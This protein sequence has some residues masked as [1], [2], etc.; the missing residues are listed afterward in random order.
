M[1]FYQYSWLILFSPLFAFAVIIFGTRMWDL[2]TRRSIA[3]AAGDEAHAHSEGE[4][5]EGPE[6]IETRGPHGE[7]ETLEDDEDPKV[8][9]LTTGAR[10]S[11]YVGIVIMALAC[12]YSWLIL[13]NSA[14]VFSFAPPLPASGVQVL[15]FD[16][17][18]QGTANYIIAFRLDHLAAVMMVVVTTVSL[19]VQFYSQ[20]YMENSAGYARFFSYLSLFAFSMLDI[21]FAQNLLVIFIG[22]ELVGLSSYLL[23]GFWINKRAKPEEDRLSPASASIEAF[24]TTRIGDVGFI[25]GIMILFAQTGTFDFSTLESSTDPHGVAHAFAGNTTLLTVAM[26]LVF[27]GAIGKSAQLP[28]SVWLPPA[29]EG[30]TPVS[31]LIHAATMVAAGVYMVARTFPLFETAGPAAFQVV[32]WVGAITAIYAALTALTQRDFKRVLAFSTISQL[33]Y[34]FVGLGVAGA[35]L[36]PGPG[37]FHL[38]THA[39]FKALLF[40]GAGSVIH[41]LHHATHK[42]VQD[43]NKMGGLAKFMP[44]TAVTWLIATLA[45]SGF[46]FFSGFY[47]KDNIIGLAYQHGYY[48]LYA[49]TLITAGLTAFYMLR[50]YILA[51]GGRVGEEGARFGGLW[52]GTYRGEGTPHESPLTITIP[53][54]LLSI[55]AIF[56]GYWT[57][58]FG[59][60]QPGAP[61]LDLGEVFTDPLTWIGVVVSLIGLGWA[62]V[63]YTRFALATIRDV[64]EG[65]V[66]L[67]FLH[68]L[69]LR[70]FYLDDIY[71]WL[72]R[73]VV[74]GLSHIEAAFDTYVVD[75][76]V[77]GVARAV[78]GAG[79]EV[80][81]AET[82]RVQSYMIGFFGGLAVL[83]IVVFALV[84]FVK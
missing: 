11:G 18:V 63:L 29:M 7:E 39:F 76:I 2:A 22:W 59:Y 1:A 77:N 43:M 42:E 14:G 79:Q 8:P 48:G 24:I 74:L 61:N 6:F 64:V 66:V 15:S 35:A 12:I 83:S 10:V 50:A 55:A 52:G 20:G 67:R 36:G 60:V 34:M 47:S 28:L 70:K 33:G 5:D 25:I 75:G 17:F 9:R 82:G 23:I 71:A 57:G 69:T 78:N 65:N 38:F 56:A 4:G 80:R 32:A 37:M 62:Y 68:R 13:L 31:A 40:L 84:M 58:F 41:A 27:C 45:I 3:P 81:Q 46:P 73:Y 54:V 19:L 72:I 16:W 51:F 53:L 49:V 30:P 44:V 21:V 26:I